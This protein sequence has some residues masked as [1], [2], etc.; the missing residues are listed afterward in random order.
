M[1]DGTMGIGIMG[2]VDETHR[3][4]AAE[5]PGGRSASGSSIIGRFLREPFTARAWRELLYSLLSLPLALLGLVAVV[6]T[7]LFGL[8]ITPLLA[9]LLSLDRSFGVLHR[10]LS[11]RLLRLEIATPPRP[12]R[13]PGL[14]GLLG[15]HLGDSA[16]WRSVAYLA[17]RGLL[18]P[19]QFVLGFAWWTY[20]VLFLAY[21]VLWKLEPLRKTDSHGVRHTFGFEVNGF[22]FDTWPRA[23]AV[24]AVGVLLLLLA[25]W[26]ARGP[27][28]LD[29][30][31]LPRLLGPSRTA[32]RLAQLVETR[33]HAINEAAATLRRIERDLHDGAQARLV[34]LGMRLGRAESRLA[35]G[36]AVKAQ[37][38]LKESRAE[39]KEIIQE[40]RE[41][42]R[43]IH[44]PA[45]DSG[46]GPALST[47]AAR[48]A[49]PA[50]VRV[51]SA[52]RPPASV[53]TML[54][55]AAA[56]LLANA[57]KHSGAERIAISVLGHGDGLR[58]L[59]TDDGRGGARLDG[60]G[61]G[62]RGLAERVRTADGIVTVDSPPGGP[63]TVTVD[64]PGRL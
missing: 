38:L 55:F 34:A 2:R 9:L 50:T 61:S 29:R 43:G 44:P 6:L 20:G 36:D 51:E 27:L 14:S 53:E 56:E 3:I 24:S 35:K 64:L 13:S 18:G 31:L 54:Y 42:V 62:L 17:L 22:Y 33:E 39:T 10:R 12:P 4:G 26:L 1:C 11:R 7:I 52:E 5:S 23:L 57:G 25:P 58:L 63:T 8:L 28:A 47:L 16:A 49:I 15:Y 37:E 60:T 59:V 21:P 40:L 41:L 48:S 30:L 45:L 19:V 32:L 46:L